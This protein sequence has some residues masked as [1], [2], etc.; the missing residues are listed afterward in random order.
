MTRNVLLAGVSAFALA[1]TAARADNIV[2]NQWYTGHFTQAPGLLFGSFIDAVGVDTNGPI[3][4]SGS[5]QPFALPAPPTT[6]GVLAVVI[7]LPMGGYL[8]VT[9]NGESGDQFMID[10]NGLPATPAPPGTSALVPPGQNALAGG[11]TSTPV[12]GNF[13][14]TTGKDIAFALGDPDFSSG[15]FALPAGTDTITGTYIADNGTGGL[16]N[17]DL[18]VE[19]ATVPPPPVPEPATLAVLAVGVAGIAL[20]R[21]RRERGPSD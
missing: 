2:G 9:D 16:G 12:F 6:G 21:R 3:L 17:M 8:T 10:V 19:G 20:A 1:A 13:A 7:T 15:T 18:I 5:F 11:L 4:P 14:G